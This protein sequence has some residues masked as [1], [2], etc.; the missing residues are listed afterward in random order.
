MDQFER[1]I[2]QPTTFTIVEQGGKFGVILQRLLQ[3]YEAMTW[4]K[5]V[6]GDPVQLAAEHQAWGL[7]AATTTELSQTPFETVYDAIIIDALI[8]AAC[9]VG[10]ELS[11]LL[12]P[13]RCDVYG[14][15]GHAEWGG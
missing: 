7:A 9:P 10:L 13:K 14:R 2:H 8:A 5:V 6:V 1:S 11:T 4:A 12:G 3:R 15:A